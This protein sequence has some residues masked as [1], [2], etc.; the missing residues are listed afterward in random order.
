MTRTADV[1]FPVFATFRE[2]ADTGRYAA[3]PDGWTLAIA[4]VIGSTQAIEAGRYKAVN[5]AGAAVIAAVSNALGQAPFPFAFGGD[6]ASFVVPAESAEAALAALAAT[7]T[8][9]HEEFGFD[10][11]I[12]AVPIAAIRAA[13]LDVRVARFA[14]SPDVSYAMFAGGG[15]A[16]AEERMKNGAFA[17]ERAPAGARPDLAGLSC[18]FEPA[19][20]RQGLIVSMIVRLAPGGDPAEFRRL[21]EHVLDLIEASPDMARPLPDGGPAMTWPSAGLDLEARL[22]RPVAR[23]RWL[24]RVITLARTAI[25]TAIFRVRVPIA[26]FRPARYIRQLVANSDYRKYDDGLRLTIDCT[27]ALAHTIEAMLQGAERDGTAI[28]GLHRQTD[29]LVTC[30]TPSATRRDHIHF[31]DGA[32]GG[33]AAAAAA[34]KTGV[35]PV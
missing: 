30:I 20:S 32:A 27:E 10:L 16:W 7:A 29:A 12:A 4:D 24:H 33:Y 21:V 1:E 25:V 13:G 8:L 19:A 34:M 2:V 18:R 23:S 22:S 31:V 5:M 9:V 28:F 17:I 14:A 3:L 6:G 15:L 11:R 35:A 26:G